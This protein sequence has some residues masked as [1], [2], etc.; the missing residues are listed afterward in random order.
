MNKDESINHGDESVEHGAAREFFGEA[1]S[2]EVNPEILPDDLPKEDDDP[3]SETSDGATDDESEETTDDESTEEPEGESEEESEASEETEPDE[4]DSIIAFA[5]KTLNETFKTREEAA[6]AL[7]EDYQDKADYIARNQERNAELLDAFNNSPEFLRLAELVTKGAS[8]VEALPL[9]LDVE[10]IKPEPGDPDWDKW[11]ENV[12]K[13]KRLRK[14]QEQ[15]RQ[16]IQGNL[17]RSIENVKTFAKDNELSD[18]EAHNFMEQI[19][20]M[21]L[22][23]SRGDLTPEILNQFLTGL[24][25]EKIVKTEKEKA[26]VKGRNEAIREKISKQE[27]KKEGDGLPKVKGGAVIT[28]KPESPDDYLMQG[29]DSFTSSRPF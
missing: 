19:D 8:F 20:K 6:E 5:N 15:A 7:I 3:P 1:Q 21:V 27:K 12:E 29:I 13:G 4:E 26:E 14:E 24:Q 16:E 2:D 9:V 18:K 22:S 25:H 11:K 28:D 10:S 17:K 23:V